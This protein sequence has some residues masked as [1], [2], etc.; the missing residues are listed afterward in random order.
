MCGRYFLQSPME[1]LEIQFEAEARDRFEP[2]FNLAP[3]AVAPVVVAGPEGRVIVLQRWGLVPSWT[4]D[5]AIGARMANARSETV[6]EK[7]A[8]RGPFRHGRCIVPADGFYEWQARP[9]QAK[10]PFAIRAANG[11]PLGFAGLRDRWEGPDGYL[12]TFTIITTSANAAMAPIHDRM[13]VILMPADQAAWLDPATP[14]ERLKALL[15]PCAPTWLTLHPVDPR[16]GNV[17]NDGPELARPW[18]PPGAA[19]APA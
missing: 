5:P 3:T 12:E 2:H 9:G 13:P 4:K 14:A 15:R 6:A 10:Q 8:F 16:V 11:A 7:P 18:A 19:G 17:R 1:T